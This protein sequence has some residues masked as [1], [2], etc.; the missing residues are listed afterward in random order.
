MY[1][2]YMYNNL[3]SEQEMFIKHGCTR[4]QQSSFEA[5]LSRSFILTPHSGRWYM[6]AFDFFWCKIGI[7]PKVLIYAI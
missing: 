1:Y 6:I 4:M 2:M 5:K 3:S 7:L